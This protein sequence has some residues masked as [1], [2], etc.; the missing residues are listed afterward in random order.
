MTSTRDRILE[1][2]DRLPETMLDEILHIDALSSVYL[3]R[4]VF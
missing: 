4:K 2:L 3:I 1:H